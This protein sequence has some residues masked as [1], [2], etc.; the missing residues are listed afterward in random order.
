MDAQQ[1]RSKLDRFPVVDTNSCDEMRHILIQ[2]C[3][4]RDFDRRQ[5]GKIFRGLANCLVLKNL[6]LSYGALSA[7]V[8]ATFPGNEFVRQQIILS[9]RNLIT[10]GHSRF[11][12][13]VDSASIIPARADFRCEF[14]ENFSHVFLRVRTN[15]LRSKLVALAGNPV[16]RNIEFAAGFARQTSEQLK[17]L[18]L[19]DFFISELDRPGASANDLW[20]AE[21][22][23][24]LMVSFLVAN[25]HNFSPLLQSKAG[26]A[27]PWQV[28]IVEDYIE[29]HWNRPISIEELSEATGVGVRNMFLT[30]KKV[31]GYTPMLFLQRIRLEHARRLLKAPDETTSV[32]TVGLMCGFQNAGH[33]ARYYRQAF[34][35]LP[36]F[37]LAVAKNTH[38]IADTGVGHDRKKRGG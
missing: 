17:L 22:E 26:N 21:F 35:E 9:G 7:D 32:T 23:Q 28:R 3:G 29:A 33:F 8:G 34:N 4:V 10:I 14:C 38:E 20:L 30:F 18:R 1:R 25:A 6:D 2:H 31:R 11:H 12:G 27:A 16:G 19:I 37:T 24:L 13:S 5:N 36:S 15:A